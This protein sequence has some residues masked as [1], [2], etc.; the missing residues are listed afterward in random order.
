M[1][2]SQNQ[3]QKFILLLFL[4]FRL[5][6]YVMKVRFYWR[7]T[8]YACCNNNSNLKFNYLYIFPLSSVPSKCV[9][10]LYLAQLID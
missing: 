6:K 8:K 2:L 10:Y 5:F 7:N 1:F 4:I 3:N 9:L